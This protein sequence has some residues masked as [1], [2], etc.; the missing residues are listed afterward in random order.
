MTG[1]PEEGRASGLGRAGFLVKDMVPRMENRCGQAAEGL[2]C[3]GK[4]GIEYVVIMKRW[5]VMLASSSE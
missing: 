2:S 4:E 3:V 5:L 1:V